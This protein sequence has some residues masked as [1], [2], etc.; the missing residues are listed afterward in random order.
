MATIIVFGTEPDQAEAGMG[1]A[2]LKL[3]ESAHQVTIID[4]T[5]GEFSKKSS[6]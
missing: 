4:L 3:T 6:D 2:I 1:G 5:N